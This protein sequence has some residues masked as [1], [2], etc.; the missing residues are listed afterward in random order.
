MLFVADADVVA[1]AA[2]VTES[3]AEDERTATDKEAVPDSDADR[4]RG[5]S[6]A[7]RAWVSERDTVSDRPRGENVS[8]KESVGVGGSAVAETVAVTDDVSDAALVG[9]SDSVGESRVWETVAERVGE[10]VGEGESDTVTSSETLTDAESECVATS[11]SDGRERLSVRDVVRDRVWDSLS[12]CEAVGEASDTEKEAEVDCVPASLTVDDSD[13]DSETV[14]SS[15]GDADGVPLS[16]TDTAAEPVPAEGELLCVASADGESEAV[17]SLDTDTEAGF[18][19]ECVPVQ[20][21]LRVWQMQPGSSP[22]LRL[23][24]SPSRSI[25]TTASLR[26]VMTGSPV[27]NA[28]GAVGSAHMPPTTA[29]DVALNST[30]PS[31]PA[32]PFQR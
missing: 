17:T 28:H 27:L 16:D 30:T 3:L 19:I 5:D 2:A 15:D 14:R 13:T 9:E 10:S 1:D 6:V 24:H 18:E 11:V 23:F 22:S 25:A 31:S 29:A 4:P 8:D 7:E 26:H 12:D 32:P 20:S 21:T